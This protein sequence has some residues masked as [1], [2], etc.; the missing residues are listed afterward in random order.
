MDGQPVERKTVLENLEAELT[1]LD[2]Q[3][4]KLL[5]QLDDIEH[6]MN[7]IEEILRV[8]KNKVTIEF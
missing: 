3:K 4:T 5:A 8:M 1:K 2:I 7:E 6:Y